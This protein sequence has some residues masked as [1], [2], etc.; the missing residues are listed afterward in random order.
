MRIVATIPEKGGPR[1]P[2]NPFSKHRPSVPMLSISQNIRLCVRLSVCVFTFEVMLKRLFAPTS[3]S[4]MSKIFDI[5]NPWGKV[6]ER[7]GLI[8]EEK[9]ALKLSKIAATKKVFYRFFSSFVHF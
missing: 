2:K 9:N 6:V 5:Q 1:I 4:R 8:F 3:R 7:S